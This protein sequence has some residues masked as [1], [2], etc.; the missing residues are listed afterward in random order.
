MDE[1]GQNY[2]SEEMDQSQHYPEVQLHTGYPNVQAQNYGPP[3]VQHFADVQQN[4]A[5]VIY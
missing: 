3:P 2:S 5:E 4:Y 1:Q